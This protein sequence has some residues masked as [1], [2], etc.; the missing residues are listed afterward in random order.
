M[1]GVARLQRRDDAL[2]ARHKTHRVQ[3][4]AVRGVCVL[5]AA[6]RLQSS[7]LWAYPWV[8]KTS[9]DRMRFLD[10]A[11]WGLQQIRAGTVKHANLTVCESRCML[12]SASAVWQPRS[13]HTT[14]L[15]SH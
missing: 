11:I 5:H 13:V 6:G 4:L 2:F 7:M 3:R 9:T 1:Q 8:V 15:N 14:R 12:V 10:L